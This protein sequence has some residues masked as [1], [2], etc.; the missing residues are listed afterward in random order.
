MNTVPPAGAAVGSGTPAAEVEIDEPVLRRL[1]RAQHPDLADLPLRH[2]A[3]GWDNI[4]YRLGDDLALRLPKRPVA[5]ALLIKEQ[6]WLPKLAGGLPLPIPVP[7]RN[8]A[9]GEGYPWPWTVHS[10]LPG[11]PADRSPP[12]AG[13][14]AAWGRFLGALH[15]P[16][17]ADA[18]RNPYRGVP[19][20]QRQGV[21]EE[22]MAA[23]AAKGRPMSRAIDAAWRAALAL[24]VDRETWLHGDPHARNVLTDS[25]RFSAVVDWGDM[26]AGDPASDLASLWML[27]PGAAERRAAIA[28][29][30]SLS[31]PLLARAHGWAIAMGTMLL[32]AGLV[33]DPRLA[34]MGEV[35]LRRLEADLGDQF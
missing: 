19:L 4:I 32:E 2:A 16:A 6:T 29:Y 34:A 10:W 35:T 1:L 9:P 7:L 11:E 15:Q 30:G 12:G 28:A 26:C 5:V 23:L 24:P 3:D 17:P 18:P 33:N 22:R 13:E 8:G 14:G 31:E 27:L 25:G 20:T 21:I